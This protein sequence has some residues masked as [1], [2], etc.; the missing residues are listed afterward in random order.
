VAALVTNAGAAGF[1]GA[2][3]GLTAHS[4]IASTKKRGSI[5]PPRL[6]APQLQR[7]AFSLSNASEGWPI[8]SRQPSREVHFVLARLLAVSLEA[9]PRDLEGSWRRR[10]DLPGRPGVQPRTTTQRCRSNRACWIGWGPRSWRRLGEPPSSAGP[11]RLS[12][13]RYTGPD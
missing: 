1:V 8:V 9:S 6:A 4:G 7:D 13:S 2:L 12:F 5:N 10:S 11:R 3:A